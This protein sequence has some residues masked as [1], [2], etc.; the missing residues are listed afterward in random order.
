M[1][2]I[3]SILAHDLSDAF[4]WSPFK[5]HDDEREQNQSA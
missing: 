5:D 1:T 4:A 2:D 3:I